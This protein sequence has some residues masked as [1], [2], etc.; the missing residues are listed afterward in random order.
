ML[1]NYIFFL[2]F[3]CGSVYAQQSDMNLS[4]YEQKLIEN[5][6][7]AD[8]ISLYPNPV[9]EFLKIGSK[10]LN[11]TRIE[12]FSILGGKEKEIDFNFKTIYLGDLARGIYLI[13]I[14]SD[15]GFTVKKLIK[16]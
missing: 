5:D 4:D 1:K 14:Y 13:K 12:I 6:K 15:K 7:L 16:K 8:A 10:G 11:I 3:V 2:F 9:G